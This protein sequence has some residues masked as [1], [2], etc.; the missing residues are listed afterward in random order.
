MGLHI[1]P[2]LPPKK[3]NNF[4]KNCRTITT[5]PQDTKMS[6]IN[7]KAVD[8]VE[9]LV[10]ASSPR[11][12]T[13]FLAT[14]KQAFCL[15]PCEVHTSS[16][17]MYVLVNTYQFITTHEILKQS[18]STSNRVVDANLMPNKQLVEKTGWRKQD[19]FGGK[20]ALMLLTRKEMMSLSSRLGN[21]QGI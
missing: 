11:H 18:W 5:K 9:R 10:T 14:V 19:F 7:P 21:V 3:Q 17:A 6:Q 8:G 4:K 12:R 13:A 16:P 1:S 15:T 20:R 2:L